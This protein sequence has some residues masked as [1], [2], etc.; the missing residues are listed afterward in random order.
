MVIQSKLVKVQYSVKVRIF[1]HKQH[2]K[3]YKKFSILELNTETGTLQGHETCST[4][5][6]N[7]VAKL[8]LNPATLD[9]AAQDILLAQ[10]EPVF[11][12]KDNKMLP[13]LADLE[14]AKD[15]LY[16]SNLK[17][18]PGTDGLTSL[19]YKE[20]WDSLPLGSS[21]HEMVVAV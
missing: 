2:Q 6:E 10:V 17:A 9:P 19:L 12:E 16:S 3:Q 11:T 4:Y 5:L 14:E 18:V 21:L 7:E 20:C 13:A 15:V 1:H 8:L